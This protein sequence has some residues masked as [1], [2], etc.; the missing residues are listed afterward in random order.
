MQIRRAMTQAEQRHMLTGIVEMDETYV[1][2]KPRKGKHYDDP[3]DKPKPGRGTK[4]TPVVGAVE[5]Q[6]EVRAKVVNKDQL[7]GKDLSGFCSCPSR[8]THCPPDDRRI[9]RL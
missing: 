1:G 4:K 9:P 8:Y 2:G 3:N 7:K 6:G 5:R